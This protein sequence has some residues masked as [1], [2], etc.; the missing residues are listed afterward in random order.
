MRN[1]IAVLLA[2]AVIALLATPAASAKEYYRGCLVGTHDNYMLRT[3]DGQLFRLHSHS[4]GDFKAHLGDVVEIKGQLSDHEREREA[5]EQ[6]PAA[7][8]AGV[9]M[10]RHGLN[11]SHIATLS[12]GCAEVKNGVAVIVPVPVP[13][14]AQQTTTTTVPSGSQTITTTTTGGALPQSEGA[15]I[16]AESESS[17]SQHFA[18]CLVGTE[19]FYVLR[20]TDGVLYRLRSIGSLRDHVGE[21]VDVSGR[22]DNSRREIDAQRQADLAQQVGVQIPQMGINVA[23]VRTISKGCATEPR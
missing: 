23:N 2:V 14:T 18:G 12:H 19:D 17:A 4:E 9:E 8:A 15:P 22:I 3:D 20:A 1:R 7:N 5:Q 10:P 6:T 11:V 21:T 16:V 13:A